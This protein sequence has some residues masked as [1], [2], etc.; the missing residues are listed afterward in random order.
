MN[1][2]EGMCH[3]LKILKVPTVQTQEQDTNASNLKERAKY[4]QRRWKFGGIV[5]PGRDLGNAHGSSLILN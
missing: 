2:E 3:I 5:L 1:Y 4:S